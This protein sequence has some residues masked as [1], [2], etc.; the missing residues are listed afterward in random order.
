M[1]SYFTAAPNRGLT[2]RM[3]YQ[4]PDPFLD[5]ASLTLPRSMRDA[6]DVCEFIW[7]KNGT[8]RMGTSRIVR[9]FITDIKFSGQDEE[10]SANLK[11][12][13]KH[14]LKVTEQLMM[15]GDEFLSYGNS[16][17]S[18][19]IPFRRYLRCAVCNKTDKPIENA[20]G[21]E[22]KDF[23]FKAYC[24][25]CK[26]KTTHNHLDRR[27]MEEKLIRIKRWSP[28]EIRL[29]Y[30]PHSGRYS[31]FWDIPRWLRTE[32]KRGTR[33]YVQDMP[34]EVI[35]TIRRGEL[36]AFDPG[37]VYHMK[38][39]PLAGIDS[40]GWGIPR[41]ISNFSQAWYVQ[42]LK[43]ANESIASDF[44]VPFRVLTPDVAPGQIDPVMN[45]D[46][47]RFS[48][49]V[50]GMLDQHRMDPAQWH[51]L[52]FPLKYQALGGEA[53]ALATPDLLTQGTDDLLN[54]IGVPAQLYRMDLELNVL[55]TALRLFQQSWP[56]LVSGFNGWLEWMIETVCTAMNWDKPETT[57]LTPVTMADDIELRQTWLQLAASNLVS[58]QTAFS[59]WGLN[60]KE[61][62]AKVFREQ[63]D[64]FE[65][66]KKF[67]E[68]M[69][70]RQTNS[71]Q[72]KGQGGQGGG[73]GGSPMPMGTASGGGGQG[74]P[75]TPMDLAAQ[76]QQIAQQLLQPGVTDADRRRQLTQLKNSN[77][78]LWALVKA[79]LQN[80]RQEA[81]SVGQ[82]AVLSGQVQP[83]QAG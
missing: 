68:D 62:T 33:F 71:D 19:V 4:F 56:H 32:I 12:F 36:F 44:V 22:F 59:P 17:S 23:K 27:S 38:E 52:P 45:A 28:K 6:L 83:Q 1:D 80:T 15:I 25:V 53:Q 51:T 82:K 66:Q 14:R 70:Q 21:W 50:L 78:T 55:P 13:L 74:G 47:G 10:K 18:V 60:P 46:L 2:N 35:E 40:K 29:V 34:W 69:K 67:E 5:M 16:F 76:A 37:V 63:A 24:S 77:N 20:E 26:K 43:R 42:L 75:I 30:H 8:Y 72:L 58:K 79:E 31:Y 65:A 39:E 11:N 3:G 57:E 61:E 81:A 73:Q 9:Y 64:F 49:S 48:S 7:L 41:L 54:G